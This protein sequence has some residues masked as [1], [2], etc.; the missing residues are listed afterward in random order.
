MTLGSILTDP[1]VYPEP[2]K[3]R[4]ERWLEG[5]PEAETAHRFLVP[6][7]RGTRSCIGMKYDNN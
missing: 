4:P 7:N 2:Y 6:F 3:F 1:T 5:S